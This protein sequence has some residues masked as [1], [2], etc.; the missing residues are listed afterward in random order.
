MAILAKLIDKGVNVQT[1]TPVTSV[2]DSPDSAGRWT[3]KTPRGDL[4]ARQI[5][6]ATNGYTAA[7]APQFHEKIV[8][9]RGICSRIVAPQDTAPGPL[10]HTYSIRYGPAQYDYLIQR[11]DGSI[12]VGGAK[13]RFW[14]DRSHWYG[15]TDDSRLI[16]PAQDYFDGLMQRQFRGWERSGA[17]TDCVWTGIMGW[18][19]DF[20]PYVGEIPGKPGQFI[21]AGFSGHGMP[22]IYL[23]SKGLARMVQGE[24]FEETDL[25]SMFKPTKERLE[26]Q[27]NEIL[28]ITTSNRKNA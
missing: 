13:Q 15:V 12:I 18:T 19:S 11:P 6:Y 1:H 2:S 7:I 4:S 16:E 17:Y 10:S 25:P 27:V 9:V 5:I 8:P 24:A 14:D 20:M 22:L 21:N 23:A 28:G 3:V 26:S